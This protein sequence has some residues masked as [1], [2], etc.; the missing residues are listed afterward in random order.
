[1]LFDGVRCRSIKF[2]DSLSTAKIESKIEQSWA[3][4][5]E[6][7]LLWWRKKEDNEG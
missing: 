3:K 2:E 4:R 6:V 1:M 5:V 7:A